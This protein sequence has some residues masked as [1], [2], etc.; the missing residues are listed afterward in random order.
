MQLTQHPSGW[1][2]RQVEG[3]LAGRSGAGT[4]QFYVS[5]PGQP[6]Q[7]LEC[8][9]GGGPERLESRE[10]RT[11]ILKQRSNL[12]QRANELIW[13]VRDSEGHS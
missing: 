10:Q 12:H 9:K 4:R 2:V 8:Q 11:E 7:H 13:R 6:A 5:R 1:L 3:G